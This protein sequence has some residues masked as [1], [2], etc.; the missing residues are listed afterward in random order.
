MLYL[1]YSS[2]NK[3]VAE[4]KP[5]YSPQSGVLDFATLVDRTGKKGGKKNHLLEKWDVGMTVW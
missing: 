4:T 5:R 3:A 1:F 2:A